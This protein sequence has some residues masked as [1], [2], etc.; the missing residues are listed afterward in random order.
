MADS[1]APSVPQP[2]S[3]NP[4]APQGTLPPVDPAYSQSNE[5]AG[6]IFEKPP[7]ENEPYIPPPIRNPDGTPIKNRPGHV[8]QTEL[9]WQLDAEEEELAKNPPLRDPNAP[10]P[11]VENG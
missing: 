2:V 4:V 6:R 5:P 3:S 9:P 10:P 7:H 8:G 1:F 11:E